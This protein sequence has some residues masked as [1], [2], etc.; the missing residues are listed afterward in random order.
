[1]RDHTLTQGLQVGGD[2]QPRHCAVGLGQDV[3][4]L[5]PPAPF[6]EGVGHTGAVLPGV[7]TVVVAL[8]ARAGALPLLMSGRCRVATARPGL[9]RDRRRQWRQ[10][11][12]EQRDVL[13]GRLHLEPRAA[14]AGASEPGASLPIG[15]RLLP[16][17]RQDRPKEGSVRVDPLEDVGPRPREIGGVQ[18]V[19]ALDHQ[20]LGVR[21]QR[22]VVREGDDFGRDHIRLGHGQAARGQSGCCCRQPLEPT[23]KAH[24]RRPCALVP[25]GDCGQEVLGRSP[26]C[27]LDLLALRKVAG[28]RYFCRAEE[29]LHSLEAHGG[30]QL[31]GRLDVTPVQ[32]SQQRRRPLEQVKR[33]NQR[34]IRSGFHAPTLLDLGTLFK[35]VF[36]ACG[37]DHLGRRT[38]FDFA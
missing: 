32:L 35:Q 10:R 6:E 29:S 2:H 9:G 19:G 15:A 30:L 18:C 17:Q 5:Q 27:R 12:L 33:L 20:L 4:R 16:L 28:Q 24:Q 38:T 25:A 21:P 36:D 1:M 8:E 13:V 11:L 3:G 7:A 22:V 37:C 26:A 14:A 34:E 31:R 23:H